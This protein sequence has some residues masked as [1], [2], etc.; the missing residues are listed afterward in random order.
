[1]KKKIGYV[2]EQPMPEAP[3]EEAMPE[4]VQAYNKHSDE[5][6]TATY[7]HSRYGF[8]CLM[9]FK[10]EALEKFKELKQEVEMQTG[11]NNLT[12]RSDREEDEHTTYAELK[13]SV[14]SKR[15]LEGI[16][17]EMNSMYENPI[18]TLV[19]PPKG[20]KT[21][22]CKLV[23]KK[24]INMDVVSKSIRILLIA[25]YPDYEI[26]QMDV[27]S[28]F[29]N[30]NLS[31]DVYMTQLEGSKRNLARNIGSQVKNILK[32]LRR[33]KE[34]FLVYGRNELRVQVYADASFRS[35]KDYSKSQSG[36]IFALN[37]GVVSWKSSKQETTTDSTTEV[38]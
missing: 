28:A 4:N 26:R 30:E 16:E 33:T 24:N 2:I 7:D 38:E 11:K 9:E 25:A 35:D 31:Q 20:V 27:K 36:Y 19:D 32:Y 23:Y 5:N 1:M 34:M 10:S 18:W 3:T 13:S 6:N 22:G 14:D 12:L 21:I 17:S 8:I 37:S 15:W 29:F